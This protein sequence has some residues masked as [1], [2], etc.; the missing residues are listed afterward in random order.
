MRDWNK[1][2]EELKARRLKAARL[3]RQGKSLS[4][5]A[6][7]VGASV[8]SIHRW[9]QAMDRSGMKGLDGKQHRGPRHKLTPSQRAD[10]RDVFMKGPAASGYKECRWFADILLEVIWDR[11]GVTYSYSHLGRMLR[12]LGLTDADL[13]SQGF[14]IGGWPRLTRRRA[15]A[16][17][18]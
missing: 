17:P 3:L 2:P 4:E 7:E 18:Y 13:L 6:R 5:V 14:R 10:L 1:S 12:G 11:Y 9:K 16:F 15:S 8:S